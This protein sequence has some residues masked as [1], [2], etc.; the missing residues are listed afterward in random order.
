MHFAAYV[1]Q[2][3]PI[4]PNERQHERVLDEDH[5]GLLS[6]A[7]ASEDPIFQRLINQASGTD[8]A[9]VLSFIQS[10][11]TE[12]QNRTAQPQP[13]PSEA[14]ASLISIENELKPD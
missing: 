2:S 4:S 13:I 6:V 14:N 9:H 10:N 8:L 7:E 12:T 3:P 1:D 5:P 11:V